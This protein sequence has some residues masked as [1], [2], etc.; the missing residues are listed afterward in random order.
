MISSLHSDLIIAY[1]GS[2]NAAED[3]DFYYTANAGNIF[4][5]AGNSALDF[6][7]GSGTSTILGNPGGTATLCGGSGSIVAPIYGPTRY[8]GGSVA[9]TIAPRRR[10]SA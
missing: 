2:E 6:Q 10:K 7:A 4:V 8:I 3:V 5:F 1:A 9:D